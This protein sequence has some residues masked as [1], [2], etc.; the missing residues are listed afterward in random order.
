[1]NLEGRDEATITFSWYIENGLDSGEY[2]AADVSTNGG[3]NWSEVAR[4]R[5]NVDPE[6]SW[7]QATIK[8]SAPGGTVRFRFRGTMNQSVEDASVDDVRAV[9]H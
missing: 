2:L 9:A 5:G 7:R 8:V 6:N 1:M 3:T 4:L